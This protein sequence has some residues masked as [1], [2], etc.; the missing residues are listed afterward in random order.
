M[1]THDNL[2]LN[3]IMSMHAICI[4]AM[5]N[6]LYF[7]IFPIDINGDATRALYKRCLDSAMPTTPSSRHTTDGQLEAGTGTPHPTGSG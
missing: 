4:P 6:I 5:A 3:T 1:I 2:Q 7:Y